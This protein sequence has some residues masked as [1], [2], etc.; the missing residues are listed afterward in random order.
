MPVAFYV[1]PYKRR[2]DIQSD[3]YLRYL[4]I[5]DVANI[6]TWRECEIRGN[7]AVVK[8]QAP[9]IVLTTLNGLYKRLPV[10]SL[11]TTLSSLSNAAKTAI[12]D[13]LLDEGFTLAEINAQFPGGVGNFTLGQVV[14]YAAR[15]R[16]LFRY[17]KV[18]DA[19]IET[20]EE[21]D[22]SAEIDDIDAAVT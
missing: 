7:R 9:S 14:R 2:T 13:E 22:N 18:A 8:V 4:A 11:D 21:S 5:L 17:D 3:L 10:D 19:I 20:T 16:H 6:T 15:H 1:V 12:R